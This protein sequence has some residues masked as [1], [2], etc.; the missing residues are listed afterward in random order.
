MHLCLGIKREGEE[1]PVD[2]GE[3]NIEAEDECSVNVSFTGLPASTFSS[4]PIYLT[5]SPVGGEFSGTAVLFS[6]F[7]P[8]LAGPGF[9]EVTYTYTDSNGC[10]DSTT[11]SILVF[12]V[13][14]NFVNYNL[15]IITP[16][17]IDLPTV[18]ENIELTQEND[19]YTF[20]YEQVSKK[21]VVSQ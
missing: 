21:I 20:S 10:S 5:G 11:Q 12:S 2:L 9:H 1:C 6:V 18:D 8:L 16:K 7:N 15:G 14:F 3:I 19:T 13:N 17:I 4:S